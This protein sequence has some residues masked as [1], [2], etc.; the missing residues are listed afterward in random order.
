ML[1]VNINAHAQASAES[2]PAELSRVDFPRKF[3]ENPKT[4]RSDS[5]III[6]ISFFFGY[7]SRAARGRHLRCAQLKSDCVRYSLFA[8]SFDMASLRSAYNN[9][10]NIVILC[11]AFDGLIVT[12][13]RT[14]LNPSI[15]LK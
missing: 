15:M 1:L 14:N 7:E 2:L 5:I 13:S 12:Y 10:N 4:L 9:N 6:I 8:L 11:L 3:Q